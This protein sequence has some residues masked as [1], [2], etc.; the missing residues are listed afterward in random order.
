MH[1][2]E[3]ELQ[4]QMLAS[5]SEVLQEFGH[6]KSKLKCR[7]CEDDAHNESWQVLHSCYF[8]ALVK[9]GDKQAVLYKATY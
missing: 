7:A 8:V 4:A 2:T 3:K 5:S 9:V 6:P 1:A